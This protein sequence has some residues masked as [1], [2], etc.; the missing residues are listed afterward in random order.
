MHAKFYSHEY[1]HVLT[2]S[3]IIKE[4]KTILSLVGNLLVSSNIILEM[5]ASGRG[6]V[7][8]FGKE[9][10]QLLIAVHI[11]WNT[12]NCKRV[13]VVSSLLASTLRFEIVAILCPLH[14]LFILLRSTKYNRRTKGQMRFR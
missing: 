6:R 14:R 12:V 1:H 3:D 5:T 11:S 2:L 13:Q 8:A 7:G 4:M 9:T 10:V